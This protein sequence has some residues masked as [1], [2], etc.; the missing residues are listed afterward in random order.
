M[1]WPAIVLLAAASY[2]LK[3]VGPLF[4]GARELPPRVGELLDIAAV[5]LLAALILVQTVSTAGSFTFDAR[6]PALG[7]AG[8]LI[9]RRAPFPLVVVA[10]AATAAALRAW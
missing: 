8:V 6:V 4:V 1:T 10:A 2:L 7:V 3:A 9:W 5:P